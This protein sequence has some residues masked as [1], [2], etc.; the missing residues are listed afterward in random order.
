[1]WYTVSLV[2]GFER[3]EKARSACECVTASGVGIDKILSHAGNA[4]VFIKIDIEGY[5][6]AIRNEIAKLRRY[7]VRGLQIA[8]HPQL[9]EQTLNGNRLRRRLKAAWAT[10]KIGQL[11]NGFLPGPSFAKFGSLA[12][13]V[14]KGVLFRRTPRGADLVFERPP[15]QATLKDHESSANRS[16]HHS[17]GQGQR[18]ADQILARR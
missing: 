18:L 8:I 10:W 4:S 6:F 17:H 13:Y 12:G 9:Y 14:I 16:L 11:F 7:R 2:D 5:E 15:A 3:A 1:M